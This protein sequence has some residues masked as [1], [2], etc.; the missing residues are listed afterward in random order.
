MLFLNLFWKSA[1]IFRTHYKC[2]YSS[3]FLLNT[4]LHYVIFLI[5]IFVFFKTIL[6]RIYIAINGILNALDESRFLLTIHLARIF[7]QEN[8]IGTERGFWMAKSVN[9]LRCTVPARSGMRRGFHTIVRDTAICDCKLT[10]R[11][12]ATCRACLDSRAR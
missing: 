10:T 6:S 3:L 8:M 12:C 11:R 2:I 9:H 7:S 5:H 4:L 1:R